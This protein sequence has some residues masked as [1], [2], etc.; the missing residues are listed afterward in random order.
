[1]VSFFDV[2]LHFLLTIHPYAADIVVIEDVT[3][4]CVLI[5]LATIQ[6]ETFSAGLDRI[7]RLIKPASIRNS[8]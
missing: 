5:G 7:D 2:D 1:M 8:A 6:G 3:G 4:K